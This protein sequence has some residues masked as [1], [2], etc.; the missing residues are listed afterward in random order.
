[1][2]ARHPVVP[3]GTGSA[4]AG[5]RSPPA[6]ALRLPQAGQRVVGLGRPGR[7]EGTERV[8]PA[9]LGVPPAPRAVQPARPGLRE[10]PPD[11]GSAEG[12]P[13]PAWPRP[14]PTAP[15]P[16]A[17]PSACRPR[18][19]SVARSAASRRIAVR[20]PADPARSR[21][22]SIPSTGFVRAATRR[23][24]TRSE[25]QRRPS[26]SSRRPT[27][28][29]RR[30]MSSGQRSS[31]STSS[32]GHRSVNRLVLRRSWTHAAAGVASAE[33]PVADRI[34]AR[35]GSFAPSSRYSA[36]VGATRPSV[37]AQR[38]LARLRL[39]HPHRVRAALQ[40]RDGRL[41]HAGRDL[42]QVHG[43]LRQ[44]RPDRA[45]RSWRRSPA[46]IRR[47]PRSR[48]AGRSARRG[49]RRPPR[50]RRSPRPGTSSPPSG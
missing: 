7:R 39:R 34:A 5:R 43:R 20:A 32:H 24:C 26:A 17:S 23:P 38:R 15:R 11:P 50:C 35:S 19:S 46:A 9:Q 25:T 33:P 21:A 16:P 6:A 18:R 1:M 29:R 8:P 49:P 31:A 45:P 47:R 36:A 13:P 30:A 3:P 44:V 22:A 14:P 40:V 28:T 42:A 37:R 10:E 48:P 41:V 27:E 12:P 2:P 4:R